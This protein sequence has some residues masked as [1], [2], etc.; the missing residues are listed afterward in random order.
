MDRVVAKNLL[1]DRYI[2]LGLTEVEYAAEFN[3]LTLEIASGK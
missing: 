1:Q 2:K 3:C